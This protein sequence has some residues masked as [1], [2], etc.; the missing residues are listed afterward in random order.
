MTRVSFF[1][2]ATMA[3]VVGC[4]VFLDDGLWD[5]ELG[6]GVA[7]QKVPGDVSILFP[8]E[9]SLELTEDFYHSSYDSDGSVPTDGSAWTEPPYASYRTVRNGSFSDG[10]SKMECTNRSHM[11]KDGHDIYTGFRCAR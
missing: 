7:G 8:N 10:E 3:T 4:G 9:S 1:L 5:L 2:L 6:L 11:I